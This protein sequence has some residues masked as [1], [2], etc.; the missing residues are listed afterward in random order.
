VLLLARQ[1]SAGRPWLEE[2]AL[3][4]FLGSRGGCRRRRSA[5][6]PLQAGHLSRELRAERGPGSGRLDSRG[7][8]R[9]LCLGAGAGSGQRSPPGEWKGKEERKRPVRLDLRPLD[10][11]TRL[12]QRP[13]VRAGSDLLVRL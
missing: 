12:R 3:R 10:R 6:V 8:T 2:A 1:G 5:G 4:G 11:E 9:L 13:G 7:A